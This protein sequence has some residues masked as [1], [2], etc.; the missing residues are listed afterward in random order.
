MSAFKFDIRSQNFTRA[1]EMADLQIRDM[2]DTLGGR[3][4]PRGSG[5]VDINIMCS[6]GTCCKLPP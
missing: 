5:Y 6:L 4:P 3:R 1:V 2:D